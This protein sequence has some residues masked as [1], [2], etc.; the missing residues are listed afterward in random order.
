MGL[1]RGGGAIDAVRVV[2]VVRKRCKGKGVQ[3]ECLRTMGI[4]SREV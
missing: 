1:G 4:K 3:M 2:H